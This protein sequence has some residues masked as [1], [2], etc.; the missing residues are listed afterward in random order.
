VTRTP[1][2]GTV[3][4]SLPKVKARAGKTTVLYASQALDAGGP[5]SRAMTKTMERFGQLHQGIHAECKGFPGAGPF[6]APSLHEVLGA[7]HPTVVRC[8]YLADYSKEGLLL[9]LD[10]FGDLADVASGLDGRLFYRTPDAQG[11]WRVHGLAAEMGSWM[12]VANRSLLK[13]MG[14]TAPDSTTTWEQF[15]HLC[16]EITRRGAKRGIRAIG[17]GI[18]H[19]VQSI[20]RFLPYFYS[21]NGGRLL[22]N[23]ESAEAELNTPGNVAALEFL[24]RLCRSGFCHLDR[25]YET[26]LD[27]KAVFG[28][29]VLPGFL[30]MTRRRMPDADIVA[31]P[32]PTPNKSAAAHTVIRGSFLAILAGTVRSRKEKLAAWEFLKFLVSAEAQGI[33][34]AESGALPARA[35]MARSVAARGGV[36]RQFCEYGMQHGLPTFDVPRNGDIHHVIRRAMV[37]AVLA[38]CDPAQAL[39]EAQEFLRAYVLPMHRDQAATDLEPMLVM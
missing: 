35:D 23:A 7:P 24:C 1:G 33:A 30:A 13:E 14:L 36:L 39:A 9:P 18:L 6:M 15:R 16:D 28:L 17:L 19:G 3:V 21:T 38:E 29:S 2:R 4:V 5:V 22:V 32:F 37:R 11:E 31:L 8:Y 26:F 20:T 10:P 34:F 12:M 25:A 27:S